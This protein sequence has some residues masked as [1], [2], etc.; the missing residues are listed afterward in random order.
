[1]RRWSGIAGVVFVV[2][3]IVSTA[4]RGSVP[5]P[6][7]RQALHNFARFYADKSHNSQALAAFILGAIGLFAFAWFIG[8]L[9]SVLRNSEGAATMPTIVVAVGG[10]AY[11][12]AGLLYHIFSEGPGITVH[13]AKGYVIDPGTALLMAS[14]ATGAFL[15]AI[16]AAGVATAA[17]ALV[18]IRKGGFP[19][20]LA[21]IG[22]LIALLSLPV[23]PP[24]AFIAAILLA[25]WVLVISVLMITTAEQA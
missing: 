23:I 5:D 16:L 19:S 11:V 13:F 25:I 21:W 12:A 18:I 10:A 8:G 2:L 14:L 9:W 4:V 3:V 7:K 6:T 24:L 22:F 1:M 17:S 20:W 15:A